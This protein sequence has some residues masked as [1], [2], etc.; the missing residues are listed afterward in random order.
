MSG[1]TTEVEAVVRSL[2][3]APAP[4]WLKGDQVDIWNAFEALKIQV[5]KKNLDYGSSVFEPCL[6][7]PHV[8]VGDAIMVR[9]A[10]KIKRM[11]S[12]RS[13][14]ALINDEA[15]ADTANDAAAYFVLYAIN[16]KRQQFVTKVGVEDSGDGIRFTDVKVEAV[17]PIA[18]A[19]IKAATEV[20]QKKAEA[21][22]KKT[23]VW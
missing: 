13:R 17:T 1:Q 6:T 8:P 19:A 2:A 3:S 21:Q 9:I 12:L 4:K 18:D 14:A 15:V 22:A 23:G 7:A 5:I 20:E 11:N 16:H 10:D